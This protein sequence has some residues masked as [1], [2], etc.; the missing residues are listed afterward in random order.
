MGGGF[1]WVLPDDATIMTAVESV[2]DAEQEK[3]T[4]QPLAPGTA[5][6]KEGE[7]ANTTDGFYVH[8]KPEVFSDIEDHFIPLQDPL[9]TSKKNEL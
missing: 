7:P 6:G 9:T 2:D 8:G 4:E 3:A 1:L 5:P